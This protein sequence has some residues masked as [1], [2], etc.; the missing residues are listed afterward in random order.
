MTSALKIVLMAAASALA[1]GCAGAW[2]GEQQSL[3]VAE[4]HPI[5]VDSQVVTMTIGLDSKTSELSAIDKARLRAFADAYINNGHGTLTV[6]APS[7]AGSDRQGEERA[8]AA[9]HYLNEVG[10]D[11]SQITGATYRVADDK[12][13]ELV[14]SYTHYVATPPS[15]GIWTGMRSRDYANLRSPNFGCSMQNNIAALVADPHDLIEP[16]DQTS[17]DA[18]SRIR[19]IRAY[20]AGEKT[21][22]ATDQNI[23]TQIAD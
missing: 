21:S 19:V 9:R 11:W 1:A 7:G 20:R 15:C 2:N 6:S 8:A 5:S 14:L 3:S 16:A 4:E 22:S 23:Q 18:Q 10:V 13:R 12:R 17:A